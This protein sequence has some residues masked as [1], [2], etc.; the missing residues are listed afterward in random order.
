MEKAKA[1][2]TQRLA[3]LD[4]AQIRRLDVAV[5]R[6]TSY[7]TV[8][9]WSDE[10]GPSDYAKALQEAANK[11]EPLSLYVHIP[12]CREM[13]T[14][15]G[16]NV[17]VS[18]D[19]ARADRY[20]EALEQ[21]IKLV[22]QHLGERRRVTRLHLGGGTPTFLTE[23]Q[24]SRLWQ[25]ISGQFDIMD[26]AELAVE[27][28]PVV[29]SREQLALL[30]GFGFRRLSMGVQDF[31]P[32][33]QQ[34][35]KRIQTVDDTEAILTYA[36]EIGFQ[37]VNFD[38]IYGLPKQTLTSW[39]KTL[40]EVARLRPDRIATFSFAYVPEVRKNQRKLE[41]ADMLSGTDKLE[42]FG[43]AHDI[44]TRAGYRPVGLDHF[45]LPDDEL[46]IAQ[47]KRSLWRDFQGYTVHRQ[48]DTIA[49]GI[50]GISNLGQNYAQNS[51]SLRDYQEAVAAG[52]LPTEKGLRLSTEDQQRG[53]I[54][55][56]IMCNFWVDVGKDAQKTY[57]DE[58]ARLADLERE[59][60]VRL[61][62]GEVSVTSTGKLFVRNVA[63]VFDTYLSAPSHRPVFSRTI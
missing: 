60:L 59:G 55:T 20:L 53:N 46:C 44:L 31:D 41:Q 16:C 43:L 37:S 22:A 8:P 47:E 21:E 50:T 63:S 54:I 34:A 38:L 18:R 52:R 15:C 9:A 61:K 1:L 7:P 13:C 39:A 2:K 26:D 30:R 25:A 29:T 12:F 35:V 28:D 42:L 5:P 51:K 32:E 19:P 49:F 3:G 4:V 10:F 36:R 40:E 62:D 56:Q 57:A 6:Y 58:L 23:K 24:L 45:A 33:V 27:I 11:T 48:S 14:Y 17:V